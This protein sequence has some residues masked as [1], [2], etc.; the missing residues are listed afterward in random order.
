M[1]PPA[2]FRA[3]LPLMVVKV[4]V[5]GGQPVPVVSSSM[6]PAIAGWPRCRRW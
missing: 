1:T 3:A 4:I 2:L 6:P 5:G